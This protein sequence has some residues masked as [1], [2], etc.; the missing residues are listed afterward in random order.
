LCKFIIYFAEILKM[1]IKNT[2]II[3]LIGMMGSGKTTVGQ[4]L[5]EKLDFE[6]VDLDVFLSNKEQMSIDGIFSLKS[7]AYFRIK[8]QL[9]L[10]EVS[11]SPKTVI[12]TGGGTPAFFNNMELMQERGTIIYLDCEVDS[13][14]VRLKDDD[15]RPLLNGKT[16]KQKRETIQKLIEER[17]PYYQQADYIVNGNHEPKVVAEDIFEFVNVGRA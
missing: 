12:A 5:A 16:S 8:E 17:N 11:S 13:L 1:D 6:F 15:N 10:I 3:F 2:D 9:A 14:V 4:I 7:A